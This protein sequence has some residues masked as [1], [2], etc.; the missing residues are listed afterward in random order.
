MTGRKQREIKIP[1]KKSALATAVAAAK[2]QKAELS[3]EIR[4]PV[5]VYIRLLRSDDHEMLSQL[6]L[7][8]D[9]QQG[10]SEVILVLGPDTAKQAVK[11][12]SRMR[13]DTVA[14]E[15]LQ[16]LVGTANVKLQ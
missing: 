11:L 9:E 3:M 4:K 2:A 10:D 15:R 1:K 6:K 7:T 14:L 13:S 16:A 8:I 5:R 12:P